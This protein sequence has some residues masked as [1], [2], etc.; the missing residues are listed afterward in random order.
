MLQFSP[1]WGVE[2][3]SDR[4]SLFYRSL[5]YRSSNFNQSTRDSQMHLGVHSL[6][7]VPR[8]EIQKYSS[9]ISFLTVKRLSNFVYDTRGEVKDMRLLKS[10]VLFM[11]R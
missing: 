8:K 1:G 5:F 2:V 9:G 7:S 11:L 3:Y 6:A 10:N 4:L